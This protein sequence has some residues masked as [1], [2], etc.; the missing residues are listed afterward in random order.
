MQMISHSQLST[1]IFSHQQLKMNNKNQRPFM[2][3][4]ANQPAKTPAHFGHTKNIAA[5]LVIMG[6]LLLTSCQ[7]KLGQLFKPEPVQPTPEAPY[8]PSEYSR[9]S[10]LRPMIPPP[11][12][13]VDLPVVQPL[14][15]LS[16]GEVYLPSLVP[17][18]RPLDF[19]QAYLAYYIDG[20]TFEGN[21]RQ[22]VIERWGQSNQRALTDQDSLTQQL[23]QYG[24][25]F[26]TKTLFNTI[27]KE[28]NYT[29]V[30]NER[31]FGT[32]VYLTY[33]D[34]DGVGAPNQLSAAFNWHAPQGNDQYGNPLP[35][36][37]L[38]P[39]Q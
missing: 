17:P 21:D 5:F 34:P 24:Y 19:N 35:L 18:K 11:S 2:L 27:A 30:F 13:E 25:A 23:N 28:Q 8:H 16:E 20:N 22:K 32:L 3:P 1:P 38:S 9:P 33:N 6:S 10:D 37:T 39:K 7:S 26:A 36:T 4:S 14:D 31:T 29:Q 12:E 15:T